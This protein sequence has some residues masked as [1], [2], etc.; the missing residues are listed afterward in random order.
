MVDFY[1]F[2]IEKEDPAVLA[3]VKDHLRH[4]H[5]ANPDNRVMPLKWD[6]YN[7]G[8]FFAALRAIGY[9]KRVGLE[10]SSKDLPHDGPRTV[11]LLKQ[12]LAP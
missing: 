3:K 9:D 1:H 6:E 5:M 11:Q 2:E 12:A 10:A 4:I 7:Y 8:P